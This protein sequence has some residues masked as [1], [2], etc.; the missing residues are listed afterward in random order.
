M[1]VH[2]PGEACQQHS[3][4]VL[5]LARQALPHCSPRMP[6]LLRGRMGMMLL[7]PPPESRPLSPDSQS[8]TCYYTATALP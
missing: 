4:S 7:V 1:N 3:P 2:F 5:T 6:A 8:T